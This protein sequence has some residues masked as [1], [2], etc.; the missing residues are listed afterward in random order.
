MKSH[1]PGVTRWLTDQK[2]NK[3]AERKGD[4]SSYLLLSMIGNSFHDNGCFELVREVGGELGEN[5]S[6]LPLGRASGALLEEQ[7]ERSIA[8]VHQST[9]TGSHPASFPQPLPQSFGDS[10]RVTEEVTRDKFSIRWLNGK[11]GTEC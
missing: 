8:V 11:C 7:L 2:F 6:K 1:G 5:L 9:L 4:S 3:K 10:P